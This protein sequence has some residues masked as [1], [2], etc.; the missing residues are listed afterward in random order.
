MFYRRNKLKKEMDY[1]HKVV[2]PWDAHLTHCEIATIIEAQIPYSSPIEN[3]LDIGIGDGI[4]WDNFKKLSVKHLVGLD[5]SSNVYKKLK[6]KSWNVDNFKFVR[7]DVHY[8]FPKVNFDLVICIFSINYF[9]IRTYLKR[10]AKTIY[11]IKECLKDTGYFVIAGPIYSDD[12][13]IDCQTRRKIFES[14]EFEVHYQEFRVI[15]DT[16]IEILIL[17][18]SSR[19]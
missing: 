7:K 18:K 1:F 9:E 8:Y 10:F 16:N 12:D 2:D 6:D 3:A 13:M 17:K 19:N 15:H 14:F 5:I 4:I 11:K